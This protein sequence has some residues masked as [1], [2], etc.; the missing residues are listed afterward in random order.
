MKHYLYVKNYKYYDSVKC[1]GYVWQ[2]DCKIQL[3][4]IMQ[5]KKI[6][7]KKFSY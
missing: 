2:Q 5:K 3:P 4:E 1:L 7:Y 6:W